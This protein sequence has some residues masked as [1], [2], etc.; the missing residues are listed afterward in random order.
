[1]GED[2]RFHTSVLTQ[3]EVGIAEPLPPH[4]S[5][6]EEEL[7]AL[8]AACKLAKGKRTNIYTDS[9]YAFGIA[10]DYGPIWGTRDFLTSAGQ[11]IKNKDSV[12]ELTN[13]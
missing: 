3:H 4:I 6:Q 9:R 12:L 5:A 1:M 11:P 13:S 10:H 8:T 2:S 7:K